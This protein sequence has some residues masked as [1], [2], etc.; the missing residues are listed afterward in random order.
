MFL[1]VIGLFVA[2]GIL[3]LTMLALVGA[4]VRAALWVVLLPL[5]LVF[6][7]LGLPLMIAGVAGAVAL[8]ALGGV[9]LIGA[10]VVAAVVGSLLLPVALVVFVV[11]A[12]TRSVRVA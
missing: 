4:V 9:L 8:A 6:L 1:L 7:A 5:R 12:L 10:G 11:W 2:V 3:G